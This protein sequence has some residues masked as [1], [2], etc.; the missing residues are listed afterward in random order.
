MIVR[1]PEQVDALVGGISKPFNEEAF[2]YEFV[3]QSI[4]MEGLAQRALAYP[5]E[6]FLG[7]CVTLKTSTL[8]L[9]IKCL[10]VCD[11]RK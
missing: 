11:C 1:A 8:R 10:V 9:A 5:I 6:V 4:K 7:V 3:V 2:Q